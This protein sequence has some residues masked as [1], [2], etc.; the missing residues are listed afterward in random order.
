VAVIEHLRES[1]GRYELTE[2]KSALRKLKEEQRERIAKIR[3]IYNTCKAQEGS[4]SC[5]DTHIA[6]M[7]RLAELQE[8]IKAQEA[9][10]EGMA[11]R[12]Q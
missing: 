1:K 8:A 9:K 10:M 3:E 7:N 12:Q 4:P 6:F 5:R 2:I 11:A